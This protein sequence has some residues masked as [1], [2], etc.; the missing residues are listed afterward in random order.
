M[1]TNKLFQFSL[2]TS[3]VLSAIPAMSMAGDVY[4]VRR[5]N[6]AGTH[7]GQ[8]YYSLSKN[9]GAWGDFYDFS[10]SGPNG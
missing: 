3:A 1:N 5:I 8:G 4:E 10:V 6:E 7:P 9:G 2:I